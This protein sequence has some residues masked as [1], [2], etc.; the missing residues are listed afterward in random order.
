MPKAEAVLW[1]ASV[2]GRS[3]YAEESRNAILA[4]DAVGVAVR[5]A[6]SAWYSWQTPM[7]PPMS[8]RLEEL[9]AI[10]LPARFVYVAHCGPDRYARHPRA[11]YQVGRTMNE[12]S[13]IPAEW[14]TQCEPMDE[15]WVPSRFNYETFVRGGIPPGK[16][17]VMPEC[18]P[19]ELFD[20][21]VEPLEIPHARGFVFLSVF[22]W[23]R[24]KGWDVL[25]RAFVEE[26]GAQEE[27][28]LVLKTT[29]TYITPIPVRVQELRALIRHELGRELRR[30]PRIVVLDLDPGAEGMPRL[31]RAADAFVLPSRGEGWGRPYMEAMAMGLPTIATR[32]SG[33]LAFMTDENSYLVDYELVDVDEAARKEG[34]WFMRS[35]L[36][37][38]FWAEPSVSHLRQVMRRVFERR[39]EARATGE[40]ARRDVIANLSWTRVGALMRDHLIAVGAL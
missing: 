4:L 20:P 12:T 18:L 29:P 5:A 8:R 23:S 10:E 33:N 6:P 30:C 36:R 26:F 24:R 15:I 32:W 2:F 34:D 9:V 27:V 1:S 21:A 35:R 38:E 14:L 3:G 17:V 28:T 19:V 37:G 7:P 25:V 31:Y 40:R 16:V 22:A 39:D 13:A 11:T